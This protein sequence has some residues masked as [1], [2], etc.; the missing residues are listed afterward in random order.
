MT[1]AELVIKFE[2]QGNDKVLRDVRSIEVELK[3][4]SSSSVNAANRFQ[5]SFGKIST[6]IKGVNF[7]NIN[8]GMSQMSTTMTPAMSSLQSTISTISLLNIALKD[9]SAGIFAKNFTKAFASLK[10]DAAEKTYKKMLKGFETYPQRFGIKVDIIDGKTKLSNLPDVTEKQQRAFQKF[11][12]KANIDML[13]GIAANRLVFSEDGRKDLAKYAEGLQGIISGFVGVSSAILEVGK[14]VTI[15]LSAVYALNAA[16]IKSTVE[17]AFEVEQLQQ[18]LE[19]L[20]TPEKATDILS[21]V[22]KLAEPSNFTTQQLAE[23]S[24]QLEAFGLNSKRI[25]PIMAQLGMAFGADAEKLR[26]LTDM[27]GRLG[28]G[29]LPDQQVMAQFGISKSKLMKE[30]IKFDNQ[31]SL[32]S[33][34]REVMIA[35]EKIVTRDY[36]AI[37]DKMAKTGNAKLASL[38]DVFDRLKVSVGQSLMD[39]AKNAISGMT[40]LLSAIERTGILQKVAQSMLLPFQAIANVFTGKDKSIGNIQATMASW[41]GGLL[42]IFEE[43]NI[44][45][46]LFVEQFA[47]VS[48]LA[49]IFQSGQAAVKYREVGGL[50]SDI[51][52]GARGTF[53]PGRAIQKGTDYSMMILDQLKNPPVPTSIDDLIN[54]S[55]LTDF[56]KLEDLLKGDKA[57]K[58][59]SETLLQKIEQHT[60]TQN[61]ITLR[62]LTYGGGELAAQG[63]S[64]VQMSGFR[65]VS[66]PGIN[67]SNDIVRG[68]E[69]I[70]RGYSNSNNLNFSFKRS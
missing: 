36:G 69:K 64:A 2:T 55:K 6:S 61:E 25:L 4:V 20:T 19:A 11:A 51:F 41:A 17:A 43:I 67:A 56:G 44:Q 65:S 15:A 5:Q 48:K 38:T 58:D 9:N 59:K 53:A 26:L 37:F 45:T 16:L 23:A 14:A 42:A 57:K 47:R 13:K 28:Q 49:L 27:F 31:G 21:F 10:V 3:K 7:S 66:S 18:R 30:G 32:V 8:S 70:V 24:V 39:T 40:D 63:L 22:R 52:K 50:V 33:S 34:T 60:K 35:I 46:A 1:F 12:P 54:N 68:V 29:Q 62:N